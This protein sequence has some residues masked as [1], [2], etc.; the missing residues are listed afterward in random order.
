M[1]CRMTSPLVYVRFPGTAR[2]ALTFYAGVFGGELALHTNADFGNDGAPPA[3]IAH[4]MVTGPVNLA[5]ADAAPG[6]DSVSPV[7]IMLSLL[8]TAE[9]AKLHRWFDELAAGGQVLDPLGPKPWGA[10]DGQVVDRYGL[11]WL[12]G[13]EPAVNGQN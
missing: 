13:Y 5:G 1:L 2:D 7:G 11:H 8:G 3:G 4:G 10:S 12:I 6:E 9:P